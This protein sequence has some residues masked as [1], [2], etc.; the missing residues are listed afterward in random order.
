[1]LANTFSV[2]DQIVIFLG[3]AGHMISVAI[4]M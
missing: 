3:I 2:M 1:M 4:V